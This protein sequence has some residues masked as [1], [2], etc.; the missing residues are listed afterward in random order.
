MGINVQNKILAPSDSMTE[1]MQLAIAAN[2]I[3][4]FAIVDATMMG[5]LM[6]NE[7][8]E[9]MTDIYDTWATDDLKALCG[10]NDNGL[11]APVTNSDGRIMGLPVPNTLGDSYP[12][13]W[14]RQD[15]LDALGLSVPSTMEEVLEDAILF[16]TKDP[17]GNGKADTY[18]L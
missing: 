11:F 14:I 13:L 5:S 4:D 2:D 18:G 17:D 1:K 15:W 7:M 16:A 9:D 6:D 12:I 8:V 10:Q 3:P